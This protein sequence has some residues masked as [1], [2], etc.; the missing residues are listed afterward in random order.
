[1]R[2][3]EIHNYMIIA[4]V[5]VKPRLINISVLWAVSSPVSNVRYTDDIPP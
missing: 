4:V 2:N 5:E 3:H 1:M